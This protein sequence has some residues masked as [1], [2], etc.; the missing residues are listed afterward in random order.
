M[1]GIRIQRLGLP[2]GLRCP[3]RPEVPKLALEAKSGPA[4]APPI[5][6]GQRPPPHVLPDLQPGL[7]AP[8]P[9]SLKLNPAAKAPALSQLLPS[10]AGGLRD[11][12]VEGGFCPGKV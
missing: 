6:A 3:A 5:P 4:P 11:E 2:L 1:Q 12:L 8:S 9:L 7:Q 10:S